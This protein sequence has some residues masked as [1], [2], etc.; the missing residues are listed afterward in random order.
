[1]TLEGC[2]P[3]GSREDPN[4][5]ASVPFGYWRLSVTFW[6]IPAATLFEYPRAAVSLTFKDDVGYMR[7]TSREG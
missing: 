3:H 4:T 1:V 7:T 5:S 6:S 2:A